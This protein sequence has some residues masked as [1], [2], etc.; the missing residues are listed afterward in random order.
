MDRAD[1]VKA[2][3]LSNSELLFHNLQIPFSSS[4]LYVTFPKHTQ[5]PVGP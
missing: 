5:R 1:L 3:T 2:H 4:Y